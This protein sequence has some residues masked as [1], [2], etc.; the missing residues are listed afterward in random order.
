MFSIWEP[1]FQL[2]LYHNPLLFQKAIT[3]SEDEVLEET[4]D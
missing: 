3:L 2:R 1:A 4:W